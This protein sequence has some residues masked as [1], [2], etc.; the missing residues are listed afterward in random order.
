[1]N[2]TQTN[3]MRMF[4]N[5]QEVLDENTTLWSSIPVLLNVKNNFDELIQRI[6]ETNEKTVLR[7]EA[8]TASKASVLKAL[9]KK[10]TTLAG[11][12]QA[13][14]A[15]TGN[16]KLAGEV[17]LVESDFDRARETDV[18][19][20]VTPV[21][22]NARKALENLADYGVTEAMI[23]ETET[24]LDDFKALI[25]QPRTIRNQ[26]FAAMSLL[27]ELFDATNDLLN[28]RLDPL[29]IRFKYSDTEFYSAYERARTIVD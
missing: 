21:I 3:H 17:K 29:M 25:G 7:S 18:E 11:T 16:A 27:E 9:A 14:A 28:N 13:Y 20:L 2:K 10:C 5:T 12:L 6:E 24:S 19:A 4:L 23:T 8:V 26:A 1:M 15:I 22:K